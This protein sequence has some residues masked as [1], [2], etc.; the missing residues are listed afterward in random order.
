[1]KPNDLPTAP[2]SFKL[3]VNQSHMDFDDVESTHETEHLILTEEEVKGKE[4]VLSFVKYQCVNTLSVSLSY[5]QIFVD[6]NCSE[7]DVTEITELD[8]YGCPI[9]KTDMKSL[10]KV[11]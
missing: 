6:Q 5:S 4:I 7:G 10:K 3:F 8:F 2:S 11:G 9:H 1:M